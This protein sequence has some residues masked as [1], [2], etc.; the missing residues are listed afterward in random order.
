MTVAA[1]LAVTQAGEQSCVETVRAALERIDAGAG[2]GAW[3]ALD[4]DAALATAARLDREGPEGRPLFGVP[5]GVKDVF[6]TAD[7]P[8]SYGSPAYAGH[9]PGADAATVA[10]LR[11][12]GA[13]VVGKTAS[14]EFAS[15]GPTRVGNPVAPG[16]SPGGSSSGSAAAVAADMVPVA[17]GTQTAGSV[18]RP[19]AY[20]AV[21][22]FKP[23]PGV[24]SRAGVL[25]VSH[26]LD[27]I[28]LFAQ[29]VADAAL[30]A[31][32]LA[33]TDAGAPRTVRGTLPV[34]LA[35]ALDGPPPRLG[36]AR[37]SRWAQIEPP[38]RAAIDAAVAALRARGA[39]LTEVELPPVFDDVVEAQR[40]I[41]LVE[42]AHALSRDRAQLSDALGA[43]VDEGLRVPDRDYWRA[44]TCLAHA[45]GPCRDALERFDAVLTPAT[46]G[47]PP[48]LPS[49]GDPLFC[50]AWTALGTP[51]VAVP[52]AV[53]EAGLPAGLQLVAPPGGD[54]ALLRAAH[55][56]TS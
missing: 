20:C 28:G 23:T 35:P 6:D 19:A 27:T 2:L 14:T 47:V 8:T 40:L 52:L 1:V 44:R 48:L 4:A 21:V 36:L 16:R 39:T 37:T 32:V 41:Q 45:A 43:A 51:C 24:I 42:T 56:V 33:A 54:A 34:T 53:T 30:V 22:G 3:V 11:R 9:R 17:L 5:V 10:A 49:T 31:R 50:R 46:T 55:W 7:L 12:A 18:I 29:T 25:P 38:A 15:L 13:I 26:T